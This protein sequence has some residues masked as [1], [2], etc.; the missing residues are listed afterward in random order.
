MNSISSKISLYI[1]IPFCKKKCNYCDFYSECTGFSR[2]DILIDNIIK[3][4]KNKLISFGNPQIITVFIGGGTPSILNKDQLNKLL[5]VVD[6]LTP[7]KLEFTIESNPESISADFLEIIEKHNVNRLSIGVQSFDKK[8]LETIGRNC[9]VED[10]YNA[11]NLVKD[12]WKYQFN[13]DLISSLP[14]QTQDLVVSD[15]NKAIEYNPDHISFYSLIVEEDTP[16][17]SQ[18]NSGSIIELDED[19]SINIWQT[20]RDFLRA[21]GYIDY[22]VSNFTKK[23]P[24]LHN[25]NYWEL[26]PYLG[27]GPG[28]VSTCI[29]SDNKIIRI[30]NVKSI[31]KY[32]LNN[33][34]NS[35][36]ETTVLSNSDFLGDYIM[37]G[38]RLRKGI[39]RSRFKSIFNKEILELIPGLNS[40][41]ND[42]LIE[43]D[44]EFIKLTDYGYNIMNSVI[45]NILELIDNTFIENV[46]WHY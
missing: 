10:V 8:L 29:N 11:L 20:G 15:I 35:A 34:E 40:F 6:L 39:N 23:N 42:G 27:I 28:A 44:N 18:I 32:I 7:N 26:K 45:V 30:S 36:E 19:L 2:I 17:E 38:F 9:T 33:S 12:K 5:S 14:N 31:D 3:E 46:N 43:S 13:I 4:L 41:I 22:E 37:M 21:N 1:H 16:L 25:I 24:C